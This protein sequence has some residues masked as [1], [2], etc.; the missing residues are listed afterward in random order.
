MPEYRYT[1][2]LEITKPAQKAI[3]VWAPNPGVPTVARILAYAF[4]GLMLLT[5]FATCFT[6]RADDSPP[7]P[8]TEQD[9]AELETHNGC[10]LYYPN[11]WTVEQKTVENRTQVNCAL[12]PGSP[13]QMTVLLQEASDNESYLIVDAM[14]KEL[15]G[16]LRKELDNFTLSDETLTIIASNG[17]A[18]TFTDHGKP[19]SGAW[20][21][22]SR[23]RFVLCVMGQ[24]PRNS[25]RETE[26]IVSQ[27]AK[28]A[29]C[30]K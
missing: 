14:K 9:W 18:F 7:I 23:G 21:I 27:M 15:T 24:A 17:Q 19:M 30:P 16:F 29:K 25:W 6:P 10:V 2:E 5:L 3:P 13:V 1:D 4:G 28:K 12:I 26:L 22:E 11:D 20:V 8:K